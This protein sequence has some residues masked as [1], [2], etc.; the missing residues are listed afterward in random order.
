MTYKE[1]K[2]EIKAIACQ[3]MK[4]QMDMSITE[5]GRKNAHDELKAIL[6]GVAD[7]AW[8]MFDFS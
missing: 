1:Y 7:E 6:L 5:A 3:L 4:D 8:N 2:N